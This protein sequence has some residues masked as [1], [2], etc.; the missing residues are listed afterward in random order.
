M[1]FNLF[2]RPQPSPEY[3]LQRKICHE[4]G[5]PATLF[6]ETNQ[7]SDKALMDL[8]R[9]DHE[10]YGDEP[11]IW[12]T[13]TETMP[14]TMV[15]LLSEKEKE[16]CVKISID[17]FKDTFGYLPTVCGNYLLDSS[18]IRLLKQYCPSIKGVV[19]GCFEEGVRVFHGC[20]N[21]WYLFSEGMSWMPWYPSK[22]HS[23]RPAADSSDWSGVVAVPHLSRDLVLS[24]ENRDD[25]FASHP[26]NIQRGLVNDGYIHEYDFNLCDQYRMQEDFNGGFSYYQIHVGSTWLSNHS[27]IIDSDEVTQAMYYET[28]KYLSDLAKEN[29]VQPMTFGEFADFYRKNVDIS[30]PTVGVGKDILMDSGKQYFWFCSP[31]YRVLIDTFQGGSIGDLRP[32][33]GQFNAF[34]GTDAPPSQYLMNSYPYLIHSQYRTGFKH[35]YEDGSRTTLLLEHDDEQIDLCSVSSGIQEVTEQDGIQTLTLTPVRITFH[36]GFS[37]T[38]QTIYQFL[39]GGKINIRRNL[40]DRS[41]QTASLKITEYIKACYGFTEYPEDMKGIALYADEKKVADYYYSGKKY[42]LNDTTCLSARIPAI[43]TEILFIADSPVQSAELSD[44]HLFSPYYTLK[45]NYIIT[46]NTKEVC[47]CLHLRKISE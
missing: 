11:A 35:H 13:P 22:G 46:Q 1:I 8:C 33:I 40:I 25:F 28:L 24:Y 39:P 26:A 15:W 9:H 37:L 12:L 41:S 34:T 17:R 45:L 10:I 2:Q 31:D 14:S 42:I 6:I 30:K 4:L 36:D 47:S 32:Y 44:G 5:L 29:K 19:A 18:L 16:E 38:L 27:N 23:L 20:N 7:F 21:S 3:E 43:F